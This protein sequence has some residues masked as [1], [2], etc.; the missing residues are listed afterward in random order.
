MKHRNRIYVVGPSSTG[1]TTL[2]NALAKRLGL[3]G[4]HFVTEVTRQVIRRLGLSRENIGLLDM[5]KAIM[6]AH[7]EREQQNQDADTQLC[8]RSAIDPIVYAV[9]TATSPSDAQTR[10]EAL[11]QMPEFQR[12]LPQYQDSLFVLLKP[13]KA[14]MVDDGFRHVGDETEILALFREILSE[15]GIRYREI[16]PDMW[17]L[18]E[19]TSYVLGLLM[20]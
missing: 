3:D 2:C 20:I 10:K 7:L 19:R 5:Q 14:W 17:F 12:I 18:P 9:F 6:S 16:G 13:V 8:D 1:K 15:L 11:I 4:K